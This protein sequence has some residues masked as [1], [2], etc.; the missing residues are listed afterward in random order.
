MVTCD[1]ITGLPDVDGHNAL[2]LIV[3]RHG[4]IIHLIPCTEEIDAEGAADNF[5]REWFRLHGLPRKIISDR[6]PQFSSKLF[7]A[8][9]KGLGIESAMSTAYH[10]Q[11]DGQSE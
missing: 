4:K 10:P 5:I 7:R 6:G 3:D 2:Q 9:L 8:I 1:F 11:T